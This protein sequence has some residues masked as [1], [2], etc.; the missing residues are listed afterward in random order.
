MSVVS[1]TGVGEAEQNHVV[2]VVK[3][4]Q[5]GSVDVEKQKLLPVHQWVRSEI[6][7]FV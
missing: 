1:G 7:S 3:S 6:T 5:L 2:G 4:M